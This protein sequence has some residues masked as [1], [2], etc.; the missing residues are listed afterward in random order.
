MKTL[1]EEQYFGF[2]PRNGWGHAWRI[3]N[4]FEEETSRSGPEFEVSLG[5]RLVALLPE[6][7]VHRNQGK[8]IAISFTNGSVL[9][10]A[11]TLAELNTEMVRRKIR[12]NCY[13]KKLGSDAV[14]TID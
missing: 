9:C 1:L 12:E 7:F 3:G 14:A 11:P 5:E 13:V 6:E 4:W 10:V 8:F 2:P